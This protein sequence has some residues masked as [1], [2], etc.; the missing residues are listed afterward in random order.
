MNAVLIGKRENTKKKKEGNFSG[1]ELYTLTTAYKHL[2]RTKHL[3]PLPWV[4]IISSMFSI[5]LK[6]KSCAMQGLGGDD[7]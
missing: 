6:A 3:I 5:S 1:A 7:E 4:Y 2:Q